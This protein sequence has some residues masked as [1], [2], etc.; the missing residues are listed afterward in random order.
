[1][2]E[3]PQCK[4]FIDADLSA[5]DLI[6][7]LTQVLNESSAHCE[8]VISKNEEYDSNRRKRFPD[9]FLYF[10]YFIDLYMPDAETFE[11]V[12]LV[13]NLLIYLWED[14]FPAIAAAPFE[15][16]LPEHGGYKSRQIPWPAD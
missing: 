3:V 12:E 16:D 11:Q 15:T 7:F 14:S 8:M 10:R 5:A 4:L 13:T 1:M 2:I 9:G 6:S